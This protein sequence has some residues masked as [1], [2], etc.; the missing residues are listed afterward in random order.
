MKP[1]ELHVVPIRP[2]NFSDRLQVCWSH[3]EGWES[4]ELVKESRQWLES[5]NSQFTPTTFI[6]YDGTTPVGMIEFMP[7]DML[8]VQDFCPCR[9]RKAGDGRV[10]PRLGTDYMDY[11]FITCLW[12]PA[13][14]QHQGVGNSLL[15]H[16]LDSQVF[17]HFRGM[18]VFA[19]A[20]DPKWPESVHW[21]AGP[22]EFYE[23]RGFQP[24]KEIEDPAG[25]LLQYKHKPAP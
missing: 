14:W 9:K 16:L 10:L 20:R 23:R 15:I 4:H 24:V 18:L 11:L 17:K 8:H 12:V 25:C 5:V 19:S 6:A 22:R 1:E 7:R 3:L 21:P 13:T 2:G